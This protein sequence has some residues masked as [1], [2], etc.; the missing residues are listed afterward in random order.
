MNLFMCV[1][2]RCQVHA[3]FQLLVSQHP[4]PSPPAPL[5]LPS[6]SLPNP[7]DALLSLLSLPFPFPLLSLCYGC[8]CRLAEENKL[9]GNV[10]YQSG[11]YK[12]ACDLYG[13]AV[14]HNPNCAMYW[15]NR[16]AA[17]MMLENFSSALEDCTQAIKLDETYV[18]VGVTI[19]II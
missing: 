8:H 11:R 14:Y 18:K 13:K 10:A 15:S 6:S 2:T 7:C 9:K 1:L 4:P 16:S 12:E 19:V 17:Q 3:L 5:S